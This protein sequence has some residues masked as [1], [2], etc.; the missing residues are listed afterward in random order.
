MRHA[1]HRQILQQGG[2][3]G[4]LVMRYEGKIGTVAQYSK[5]LEWEGGKPHADEV[6]SH[7]E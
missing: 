5:G 2:V 3:P 1:W 6:L 7:P 4:G